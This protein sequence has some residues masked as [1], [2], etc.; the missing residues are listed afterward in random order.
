MAHKLVVTK[1]DAD[2]V[3]ALKEAAALHGRSPED[4]H[5]EILRAALLKPVRRSFKEVLSSMP[6]VGLDADYSCRR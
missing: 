1:V 6:D 5:R 3:R 2:L 4:E